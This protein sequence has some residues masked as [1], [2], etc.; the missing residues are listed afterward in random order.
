MGPHSLCLHP[1]D[2][3]ITE[4]AYLV[5]FSKLLAEFSLIGVEP[6][7]AMRQQFEAALP[8]V[9]VVEGEGQDFLG[10]FSCCATPKPD[11]RLLLAACPKVQCLVLRKAQ[12]GAR[13]EHAMPGVSSHHRPPTSC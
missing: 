6:V 7:A 10:P 5:V 13:F 4:W 11:L 1:A 8:G 2:F 3:L 12:C 9:L